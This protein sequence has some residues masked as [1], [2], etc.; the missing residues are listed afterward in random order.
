MRPSPIETV[1]EGPPLKKEAALGGAALTRTRFPG[2][3]IHTLRRRA[4]AKCRVEDRTA[5]AEAIAQVLDQCLDSPGVVLLN[6][7][8]HAL[9]VMTSA[10][11]ASRRWRRH[12]L[13]NVK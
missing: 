1:G 6:T 12:T 5:F 7:Y 11:R 2:R 13:F 10:K 3:T 8:R 9:R 4:R